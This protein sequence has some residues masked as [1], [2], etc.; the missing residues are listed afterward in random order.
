MS[1]LVSDEYL[2]G[3]FQEPQAKHNKTTLYL[4]IMK[5]HLQY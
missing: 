2:F 3:F 5:D 4:F 1:K